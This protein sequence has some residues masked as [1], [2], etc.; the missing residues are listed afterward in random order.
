MTNT[1][2]PQDPTPGYTCVD[3]T[4]NVAR[5][6]ADHQWFPTFWERQSRISDA[7]DAR[8]VHRVFWA[9]YRDY[10][11]QLTTAAIAPAVRLA[12]NTAP[13]R[14]TLGFCCAPD[15]DICGPENPTVATHGH[16]ATQLL[17]DMVQGA[18]PMPD[19]FVLAQVWADGQ[20]A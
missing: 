5:L 19:P 11:Q 4:V 10:S 13:T 9:V 17:D 2:G 18:A 7:A 16:T 6:V 3:V 14:V 1:P 12:E 20:V 8:W 15:A